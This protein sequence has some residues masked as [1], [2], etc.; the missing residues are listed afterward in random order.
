MEPKDKFGSAVASLADDKFLVG[1]EE[2]D[3][4]KSKAGIAYVFSAN[5]GRLLE[6]INNPSPNKNDRF[7]SALIG[8]TSGK[9]VISAP[10]DDSGANGAGS[11][12]IFE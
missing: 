5:T 6:T 4:D 1:A 12:Y 10:R 2:N 7:G 3:T 9:M 8:L 11:I